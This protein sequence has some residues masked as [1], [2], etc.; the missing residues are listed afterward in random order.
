MHRTDKAEKKQKTAI[1]HFKTSNTD[2]N[3]TI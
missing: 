1:N 3:L 2:L